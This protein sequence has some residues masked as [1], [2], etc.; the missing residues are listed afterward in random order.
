MAV[1]PI[2]ALNGYMGAE[3]SKGLSVEDA[4]SHKEANLMA[5]DAILNHK[6]VASFANEKILVA[7]FKDLLE[8]PKKKAI[9]RAHLVGVVYGFS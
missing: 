2:M 9:R 7:H 4:E 5:G 3:F 8:R 1:T 6:T